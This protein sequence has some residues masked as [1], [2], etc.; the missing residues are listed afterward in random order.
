MAVKKCRECGN[1]VS[2]KAKTCPD[3]GVKSPVKATI[4]TFWGLVIIVGVVWMIGQFYDGGSSSS[5]SYSGSSN[6]ATSGSAATSSSTRTPPPPPSWRTSNSTDQITGERS[7]Y[8]SSPRTTSTTPM[9]FPYSDAQAWLGVGCDSDSEWAYVG[10]TDSPNL[11][12]DETRDGYNE[13]RTRI[14]WDDEAGQELFT[15]AWGADFL[16]FQSDAATIMRVASS[17]AFRLELNWY[18]QGRV[19]FDFSLN[20][21]SQA[22]SDIRA[23]CASY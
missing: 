4:S 13:I 11:V 15:Q 21:S 5:S 12:D 2:S 14:R 7:A 16:H 6:T 23:S 8:A 20:G 18:G 17:N 9:E 3:C 22:I 19:Y 1:A 10:F